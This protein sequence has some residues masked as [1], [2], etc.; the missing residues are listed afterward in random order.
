MRFV[1]GILQRLLF[2]NIRFMQRF[3]SY[4]ILATAFMFQ[5]PAMWVTQKHKAAGRI[6]ELDHKGC[7]HSSEKQ[8]YQNSNFIH[9]FFLLILGTTTLATTLSPTTTTEASNVHNH[10]KFY[11]SEKQVNTSHQNSVSFFPSIYH[12][13]FS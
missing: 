3:T 7:C 4:L 2:L 11:V 10:P 8:L 12:T 13:Y 5:F 1:K 6:A 9:F